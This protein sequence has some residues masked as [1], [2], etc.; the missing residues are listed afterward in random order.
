MIWS[1]DLA[2]VRWHNEK[3]S[4]Y[5]DSQ[6]PLCGATLW[7]WHCTLQFTMYLYGNISHGRSRQRLKQDLNGASL[8]PVAELAL[9]THVR[10]SGSMSHGAGPWIGSQ[11]VAGSLNWLIILKQIIL[12]QNLN[13]NQQFGILAVFNIPISFVTFVLPLCH[14]KSFLL[15]KYS[16]SW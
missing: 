4:S 3:V 12:F 5:A 10:H 16:F 8:L 15:Q 13:C 2:I 9:L 1:W 6:G 7:H 11:S 14:C